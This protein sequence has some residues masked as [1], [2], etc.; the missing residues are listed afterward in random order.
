MKIASTEVMYDRYVI[1]K[2]K[3]KIKTRQGQNF[4][5]IIKKAWI[6]VGSIHREE[7]STKISSTYGGMERRETCT[8]TKLTKGHT[9]LV[10]NEATPYL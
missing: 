8:S 1:I 7:K 10:S 4:K 5:Q 6:S 2:L 3:E 9:I